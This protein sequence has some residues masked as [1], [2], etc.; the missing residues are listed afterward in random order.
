MTNRILHM[1]A[2]SM[3]VFVFEVGALVLGYYAYLAW[4][5]VSVTGSIVSDI[6]LPVSLAMMFGLNVAIISR[7]PSKETE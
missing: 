1:L 4:N 6:L 7:W 3:F 2:K 5:G